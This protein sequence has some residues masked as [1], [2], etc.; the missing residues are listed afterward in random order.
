MGGSQGQVVQESAFTYDEQNRLTGGYGQSFGWS[1]NGSFTSFA[2]APF[3]YDALHPHAVETVNDADRY[4][5]NLNGNMYVRNKNTSDAQTLLWDAAN[6]L[7]QVTWGSPP[8]SELYGYDESG[9][10]IAKALVSGGSATMTYYPFAWYEQQSGGTGG[11][12]GSSVTKYYFF[13]NE[14]FAMRTGSGASGTFYL[15]YKDRLSSTIH[16]SDQ[17]GGYIGS[18]GYYAFGGVMRSD[19]TIPTDHRFTDQQQDASGLLF[20]GARYYDPQI[21]QFLSPDTIVP[22][23]TQVI[24]YQRYGYARG[25]PLKYNDP[26]GHCATEAPSSDDK[27]AMQSYT[28]CWR[29]AGTILSMYDADPWWQERFRVD[30]QTFFEKVIMQPNQ[31]AKSLQKQLDDWEYDFKS[32]TGLP[33][34]PVEWHKPVYAPINFPGRGM[35]EA[36]V[37]DILNCQD[38]MPWGCSNLADDASAVVAGGA[39]IVCAAATGGT[40]LAV[41]GG[42]STIISGGGSALT[43]VNALNGDATAAD[44]IVSWSTTVVGGKFGIKGRGVVGAGVSTFQRVYDWWASQ[45]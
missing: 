28:D 5:Y 22:D 31:D 6:R 9:R 15:L 13:N 34:G 19:G 33:N 37:N 2:G 27:E 20:Y 45:Q 4:D 40:C 7:T 24:D 26:N 3:G 25:N 21:G 29:L 44:V 30:Q 35:T 11:G 18:M 43:T 10:R 38:N 42:A 8:V 1:A 39:V 32:H 23:P 16:V 36:V 17:G 14:R 12:T 41:G